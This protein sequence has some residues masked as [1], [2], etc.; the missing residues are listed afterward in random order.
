MPLLVRGFS[1]NPNS[2]L[3]MGT[4]TLNPDLK[5]IPQ[6]FGYPLKKCNNG[7]AYENP[8][9]LPKFD[10]L[11]IHGMLEKTALLEIN[12]K[13]QDWNYLIPIIKKVTDTVGPVADG[14]D[15]NIIGDLTH[16]YLDFNKE[17]CIEKSIAAI[18]WFFQIKGFSLSEIKALE[19]ESIIDTSETWYRLRHS[20][21]IVSVSMTGK[22]T[23]KGI[24]HT[25]IFNDNE[26]RN[27]INV[28]LNT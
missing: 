28:Y 14:R 1:F 7:Y 24:S 5:L 17:E 21:H 16:S 13:L 18:K 19:D 11:K 9:R 2:I 23:K 3:V 27:S 22:I 6:F 8:H 20:P 15:S 10:D 12:Y 26:K 4:S 25:V